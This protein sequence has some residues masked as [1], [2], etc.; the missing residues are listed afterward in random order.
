MVEEYS[1]G[2]RTIFLPF[3]LMG[4]TRVCSMDRLR[5]VNI[6]VDIDA[7][8]RV[9]FVFFFNSRN[10]MSW[11]RYSVF[12]KIIKVQYSYAIFFFSTL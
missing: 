4:A 11:M 1:L 3:S 9:F 8:L 2:Q 5:Y 7:C 10:P 12:W 6:D